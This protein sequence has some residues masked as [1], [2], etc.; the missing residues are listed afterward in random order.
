MISDAAYRLP[1]SD[2]L[3]SHGGRRV[4]L[5]HDKHDPNDIDTLVASGDCLI[6]L[7]TTLDETTQLLTT[8]PETARSQIEMIIQ[9]LLHL[10]RDYQLVRKP[11]DRRQ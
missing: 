10:Q 3:L 9:T 1:L 11:A 8:K 5:L 7:A 4:Q 6:T 2:A